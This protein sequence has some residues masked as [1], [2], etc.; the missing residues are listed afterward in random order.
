LT[1][2]ANNALHRIALVRMSSDARTRAYVTRQLD[3]GRTKTEILRLLK[4]AIT[5]EMFRLLTRQCDIDDYR[6]LRPTRQT[7]NI[8]LTTVAAH[9]GLW[10]IDISR[11]ERGLKRDDTLAP[12]YRQW[13]AAAQKQPLT[14]IGASRSLCRLRDVGAATISVTDF[15][16]PDIFAYRLPV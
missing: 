7:K 10:P 1:R 13:L 2:A 11:L 5:R 12:N 15:T 14:P 4:R 3:K 8:T 16:D 6:D 9:F